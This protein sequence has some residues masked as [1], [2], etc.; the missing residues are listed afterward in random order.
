MAGTTDRLRMVFPETT[1]GIQLYFN[2]EA[3]AILTG[4]PTQFRTKVGDVRDPQGKD[5]E[6]LL[7]RESGATWEPPLAAP[8]TLKPTVL[9]TNSAKVVEM[10]TGLSLP[11]QRVVKVVCSLPIAARVGAGRRGQQRNS[12]NIR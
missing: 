4:W 2:L 3:L 10:L 8:A 7:T 5:V 11:A 12:A 9:P 1:A 6:L